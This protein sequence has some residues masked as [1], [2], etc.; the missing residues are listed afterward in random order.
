MTYIFS[1]HV[2]YSSSLFNIKWN[3]FSF[4]IL[5]VNQKLV[6]SSSNLDLTYTCMYLKCIIFVFK[7]KL[8]WR[9]CYWTTWLHECSSFSNKYTF[10][11]DNIIIDIGKEPPTT[12]K[13]R[14]IFFSL[15]HRITQKCVKMWEVCDSHGWWSHKNH[16]V[17]HH[18]TD[19]IIIFWKWKFDLYLPLSSS[20]LVSTH[21]QWLRTI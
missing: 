13:R 6:L 1:F 14:G 5:Q 18:I 12:T 19:I 17:F 4:L 20:I 10:F 21:K 8:I 9:N 11:F 7:S 16:M 2:V 15:I 3:A